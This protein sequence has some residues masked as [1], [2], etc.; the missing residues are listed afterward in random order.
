ME[1]EGRGKG[2]HARVEAKLGQRCGRPSWR[3]KRV[4]IHKDENRRLS[5]H[6]PCLTGMGQSRP[7]FM[8]DARTVGNGNGG[9]IVGRTVVDHDDLNPDLI[10]L[11][12]ECLDTGADTRRFV[13]CGND[14]GQFRQEITHVLDEIPC[15]LCPFPSQFTCYR[16]L[17]R[18]RQ[19]PLPGR[20]PRLRCST[21]SRMSERTRRTAHTRRSES[22]SHDHRAHPRPVVGATLRR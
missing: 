3:E 12:N 6:Q 11:P 21:N 8:H 16:V 4:G 18:C 19:W 13:A 14:K 20:E 10:P 22:C 1:V 9:G 2:H 5:V 17:T 7:R 15:T